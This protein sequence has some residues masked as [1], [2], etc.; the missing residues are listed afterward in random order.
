MVGKL[1]ATKYDSITAIWREPIFYYKFIQGE[2]TFTHI[3]AK[4]KEGIMEFVRRVKSPQVQPLT[5]QGKFNDF[6]SDH[7]DQVFFFYVGKEN[8]FQSFYKTFENLI[9]Q[10]IMQLWPISV[11]VRSKSYLRH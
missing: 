9:W 11:L 10:K 8:Q 1:D 5:T 3:G 4:S 7:S 6:Q 2:H